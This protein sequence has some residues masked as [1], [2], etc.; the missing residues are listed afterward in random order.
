MPAACRFVSLVTA[1]FLAAT[2][3]LHAQPAGTPVEGTVPPVDLHLNGTLDVTTFAAFDAEHRVAPRGVLDVTATADRGR[4][5]HWPGAT[6][7]A[8][9]YAF[10]GRNGS[11]IVGDY[12]GVSSIDADPFAHLGE[13]SLD[14]R[15]FSDRLR[16]RV[17]RLDANSDFALPTSTEL[18]Q[19]SSAG[20][21]GAIYPMPTYPDPEPGVVAAFAGP[22]RLLVTGGLFAGPEAADVGEP[23]L[24]SGRLWI[25]QVATGDEPEPTRIVGGVYRHTGTFLDASG[26]T[27]ESAGWFVLGEQVAWQ[28]RAGR[29]LVAS[30]Q[31]S[32]SSTRTAPVTRHLAV[33]VRLRRMTH[34][35]EHD[36]MGIRVSLS[37]LA[38]DRASL[39]ADHRAEQAVEVFHRFTLNAWLALQPDIQIVRL[40]AGEPHRTRL[41]MTLRLHV[42]R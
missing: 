5:A 12:G 36:A 4:L 17:G 35:R 23:M 7:V 3:P 26:E 11:R 32:V 19:H 18:F 39:Q 28:S 9:C 30:G 8:Q 29:E 22:G 6:V 21:S 2:V 14:V 20:L 31:L 10:G 37:A 42:S 40:P 1:L 25:A 24:E 33:G 15:W 27:S 34:R 13:L 41:A 16:T 38:S